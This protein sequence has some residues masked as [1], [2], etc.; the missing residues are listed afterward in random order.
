MEHAAGAAYHLAIALRLRGTLDP[1]ALRATL[2]RIVARH[3]NLRTCFVMREGAPVQVIAPADVGFQ[4]IERDLC[5]LDV[6]A[7]EIAI[8]EL[9]VEEAR[10]P[11]DLA[12]GPLIRGQ[13][14]VLGEQDHMLLLT[15]HH[16]I[17]DGWSMGVLVKEVSALYGAFL[18]GEPDPL[19]ELAIQYADYAAWQRQWLQGEALA[20]QIEFWRTHLQGAPALLELPTDRPRP[21]VQTYAG[22]RVDVRLSPEL[23]A[24]RRALAQRHGAT[25]FMTLLAD[26]S[27]LLSRLSGQKDVVVGTPVANRQRAEVEPLIGFFVNTLALRVDLDADPTVAE[28]LAQVKSTTLD[29]Y[30]HQDLPFEQ[31]VEALAPERSL[32]YSPVFQAVL[33]LNNTRGGRYQ[34]VRL[35]G[36]TVEPVAMTRDTAHFDIEL[37]LND[38]GGPL[39]GHLAY[40]SDLFDRDTIERCARYYVAVLEGMVASDAA[41]VGRLPLL[42]A[43]E[44]TALLARFNPPIQACA[45]DRLPHR[46]FEARV[47]ERPDAIAV[48]FE[49]QSLSYAE[50][51][52][53]AN[54]IARGLLAR[55]VRPDDRVAL[56]C[57]RGPAMLG[58][59][60]TRQHSAVDTKL[61][62][63]D[64][65]YKL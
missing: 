10:A 34:D 8:A 64:S 62:Q 17:S 33:S 9:S 54:R 20:K 24:S 25:R 15:Q 13:L 1:A 16:I 36:L 11:F 39:E 29:A 21:A 44:Q 46:V 30:A 42:A 58:F 56:C 40:A 3:E 5:A 59:T 61:D 27:L 37:L 60:Q 31:V 38:D 63:Q 52:R 48:S 43:A 22:D 23:T 18:Q 50:L 65:G 41:R 47:R 19:P 51:N 35:P 26:W 53:R 6:P 12:T 14:L 32:S 57:S 28:L 7:Q 2:D 45:S 55:G 4:L 49:Q